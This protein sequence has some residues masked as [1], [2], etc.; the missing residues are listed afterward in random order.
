MYCQLRHDFEGTLN[1]FCSCGSEKES[2]ITIFFATPAAV[3]KEKDSEGKSTKLLSLWRQEVKDTVILNFIKEYIL[4]KKYLTVIYGSY[5]TPESKVS[6]LI[7]ISD[8]L[9]TCYSRVHHKICT[10]WLKVFVTF[11]Y[12]VHVHKFKKREN[13]YFFQFFQ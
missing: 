4:S 9:I 7:L 11:W 12:W 1:P 5:K 6:C 13:G 8:L 3:K 10:C 2:S